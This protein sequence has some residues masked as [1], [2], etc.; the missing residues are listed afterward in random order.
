M[1]GMGLCMRVHVCGV[2][3]CVHEHTAWEHGDGGSLQPA[4][5]LRR[6]SREETPK[7]NAKG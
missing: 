4:R 2:Y 3:V 5:Q 1:G 7:V 6:F